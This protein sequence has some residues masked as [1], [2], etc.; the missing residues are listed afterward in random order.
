VL[1]LSDAVAAKF[2][3]NGVPLLIASGAAVVDV[4]LLNFDTGEL[5]VW[6]SNNGTADD[7][8]GVKNVGT[9][10]NQVS[11]S[12]STISFTNASMV[13]YDVATFTGGN[14]LTP[15]IITFNTS[16]LKTEVQ[17]V[18]KAI[19]FVNSSDNPSTAPRT[20]SFTL[21][22]GDSGTSNTVTRTVNVVAVNDKPV[23]GDYGGNLDYTLGDAPILVA[24]A[25]TVTD[26]DS[27]DFNTGKIVLTL[28]NA[29]A[30]DRI[31]ISEGDGVT[32]SGNVVSYNGMA[33]GTFSGTTSLTILFNSASATPEAAQAVL[34]RVTFRTTTVGVSPTRTLTTTVY[35]GDMG[36]S[37]A[38]AKTITVH[39]LIA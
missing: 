39:P 34:R 36:V 26:V 30:A 11:V 3:E 5:T 1:T 8:L 33:I 18:M 10:A 9:G 6:F 29:N 14:G 2:T 13:T 22:D 23:V 37:T 38:A 27:P 35:D 7:A 31:E 19:T 17:A 21:T 32:I 20:V 16:A 12:G 15:L 4:D 24:A 28:A 25:A